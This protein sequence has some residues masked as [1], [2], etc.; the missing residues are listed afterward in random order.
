MPW[1]PP[2]DVV[3]TAVTMKSARM[4]LVMYVFEPLTTK[5]PSTRSARVFSAATSDPASGSVMPSAAI[6]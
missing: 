6:F 2:S 5:P 1:C 4:P 3:L